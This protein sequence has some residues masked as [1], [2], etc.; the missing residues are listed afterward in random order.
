MSRVVQG[1]N[2]I[3]KKYNAVTHKGVD[4]GWRGGDNDNILAHSQGTVVS[5]VKGKKNNTKT[6]GTATY[7]NYIKIKHSNG[8]YTLYAH[9]SEVYVKKN[10]KVQKG[11]KIGYMGDSGKANG[12]HLH[13][14]VRNTK[15]K[16]INPTPYLES[17][18]PDSTIKY[19]SYDNVK[20]KWLPKVKSGT[21]DYAGNIGNGM[22]GIKIEKLTYRSYDLVKKKWLPKVTGDSSYAGNLP[23]NIGGIE[24]IGA[25]F[26]V[27]I[28]GGKWVKSNNGVAFP[29][30]VI[31]AI[32][33]NKVN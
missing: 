29:N 31:D 11:A 27:H 33:I 7:G 9:L 20:N 23:N 10:E 1:G 13:F 32:R 14:E 4:I 18:L 8:Y 5:V 17:D 21:K 24:I 22:S 26:E 25:E 12:K 28:K 19:R 16:R 2:G 6:T 15:D 3:T 30:K